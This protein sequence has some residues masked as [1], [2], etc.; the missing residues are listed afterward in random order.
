MSM[1]EKLAYLAETKEQ[2]KTALINKGASISTS[3]PF[4]K[5]VDKINGIEVV[6]NQTKEITANGMYTPDEGY[7]GFSEVIVNVSNSDDDVKT[8]KLFDTLDAM[9]ASTG[10]VLDDLAIVYNNTEEAITRTSQIN[11]LSFP[12]LVELETAITAAASAY[13]I[14]AENTSLRLAQLNL[15]KTSFIIRDYDTYEIIARYSSSDG[16]T[17]TRTTTKTSFEFSTPA[18]F[19]GTWNDAYGYFL[20]NVAYSFDGLFKYQRYVD[21]RFIE[22]RVLGNTS[23]DPS[24]QSESIYIGDFIDTVPEIFSTLPPEL[25]GET[26]K[27]EKNLFVERVDEQHYIAYT[28]LHLASTGLEMMASGCLG[29]TGTEWYVALNAGARSSTTILVDTVEAV[30]A[31]NTSR[32]F[33]R[34][35]INTATSE[36]TVSIIPASEFV[37]R[38]HL[39]YD[40][41]VLP[42]PLD[43]THKYFAVVYD[44]VECTPRN[45]KVQ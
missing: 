41:Y 44:G 2:I 45:N 30:K 14:G 3:T 23:S 21:E 7:T 42:T 29:D 38:T 33:I 11:I 17:Y 24:M 6:N 13:L 19:S 36:V 31:D 28:E 22:A 20:Q 34:W 39:S 10:N 35:E 18:K 4:R 16:I 37:I 40:K 1:N 8:I 5:Y 9:Q 43:I 15:S 26:I 27:D 12:E 25:V 32:L